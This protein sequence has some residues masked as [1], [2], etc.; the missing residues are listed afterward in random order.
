MA[1]SFRKCLQLQGTTRETFKN[2]DWT[3]DSSD[4]VVQ[5]TIKCVVEDFGLFDEINGFNRDR[6]VKQFGGETGRAIV[7]RCIDSNPVGVSTVFKSVQN[8]MYC[9]EENG[10]KMY[11]EQT[12]GGSESE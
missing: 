7:E 5:A 11:V 2:T 8:V 1:E 3:L 12:E 4:P 9:L 10:L 6:V